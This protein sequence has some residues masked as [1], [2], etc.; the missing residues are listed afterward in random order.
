MPCI[1]LYSESKLVYLD[2]PVPH[3]YSIDSAFRDKPK[4]ASA[5]E[6]S[7]LETATP[8]LDDTLPTSINDKAINVEHLQTAPITDHDKALDSAHSHDAESLRLGQSLFPLTLPMR[9]IPPNG[10]D[11][12]K[13]EY[14]IMSWSPASDLCSTTQEILAREVETATGSPTAFEEEK[15]RYK[16][17]MEEIL[18]GG[19]ESLSQAAGEGGAEGGTSLPR[20]FKRK[21]E[22]LEDTLPV[23][24]ETGTSVKK[25]VQAAAHSGSDLTSS[26]RSFSYSPSSSPPSM[27][28][29]Q[30]Q[31]ESGTGPRRSGR[32]KQPSTGVAVRVLTVPTRS[33]APRSSHGSNSVLKSS[34][35]PGPASAE[36]S[37]LTSTARSQAPK[38]RGP[39]LRIRKVAKQAVPSSHSSS[40]QG[41][42]QSQP[43]KS[44]MKAVA[45]PKAPDTK[46][47]SNPIVF[48]FKDGMLKS[49]TLAASSARG[50]S[51]SRSGTPAGAGAGAG[52]TKAKVKGR[53]GR[54]RHGA[55]TVEEWSCS[56]VDAQAKTDQ[57]ANVNIWSYDCP[58]EALAAKVA[59]CSQAIS[60]DEDDTSDG[61]V[62][63]E[64][65]LRAE[66]D[67]VPS[68]A[69]LDE[70]ISPSSSFNSSFDSS[71]HMSASSSS[72]SSIS[73]NFTPEPH[74]TAPS[75]TDTNTGIGVSS[76]TR[77]HR[78]SGLGLAGTGDHAVDDLRPVGDT[79]S[80]SQALS[81]STSANFTTTAP[82]VLGWPLT[83]QA[84]MTT[85]P[86]HPLPNTTSSLPT[87]TLM[88]YGGI[89]PPSYGPVRYR[90]SSKF[91]RRTAWAGSVL[92]F[93][94][95]VPPGFKGA[96]WQRCLAKNDQSGQAM[97]E[98]VTVRAEM[99]VLVK[100]ELGELGKLGEE[101]GTC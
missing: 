61:D 10:L 100:G 45:A 57:F 52:K 82:V 90:L 13:C 78:D 62:D 66:A 42:L 87:S 18:H 53:K 6:L 84:G 26:S 65:P 60:D 20:K 64:Y 94:D 32:N 91:E 96:G 49:I 36:E 11:L 69:T 30:P 5:S 85:I 37:T 77:T 76:E 21:R 43:E 97:R 73:G 51:R 22:L 70:F 14:D 40:S 99:G 19:A 25:R 72:V 59:E 54:G 31:T 58:P 63:D 35:A 27:T 88:N 9:L 29:S 2:C 67:D 24:R 15:K 8:P 38:K 55:S 89:F 17:R 23:D 79:P 68:F 98:G 7:K 3:S 4:I 48:K 71:L 83:P 74:S 92:R 12:S 86:H 33:R 81:G 101:E 50:S 80:Q 28:E 34:R 16:E 41:Q 44:N 47:K 1:V 93:P 56:D 39:V 46:P 95:E 75:N